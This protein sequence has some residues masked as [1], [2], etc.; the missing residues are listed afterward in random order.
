MSSQPPT[1]PYP[2]AKAPVV[3][4]KA[5]AQPVNA[6][7]QV[8]SKVAKKLPQVKLQDSMARRLAK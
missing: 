2:A 3:P 5:A 6:V 7:A 8:K 1:P 4:P